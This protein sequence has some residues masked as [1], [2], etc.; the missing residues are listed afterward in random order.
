MTEMTARRAASQPFYQRSRCNLCQSADIE[1]V[2]GL[3]P[4]P[5][6]SPNV[7]ESS[8]ARSAATVRVPLDVYLCHACGH[9]QLVH[10][11][12]PALQYTH[13]QY[14]TAI[15]LGLR[16]HFKTLVDYVHRL[17]GP[18]QGKLVAE[19]GSNDGTV[20]ELFKE[21]GYGV[22]GVDP[23]LEIARKATERGI[24]TIGAFFDQALAESIVG[25]RGKAAA[26]IANNVIANIDDLTGVMSG[27][28]ALLAPDGVFVFETGYGAEVITSTLLD[29]IYHE[30]ISYFV[31]R[32]LPAFLERH[33]LELVDAEIIAS[34][35]GSLRATVQHRNG[36]RPR[37]ANVDRI[38]AAE[39]AAGLDGKAPF[40]AFA[41]R[42][43]AIRD[44][45]TA[46][47]DRRAAQGPAIGYGA[48][49]GSVTLINYFRL[50]Q[51]L[52]FIADDNPLIG[53]LRGPDYEIPVLPSAEIYARRPASAVVLAWRYIEPIKQRHARFLSE[54]G[55]FAVPLPAFSV[56]RGG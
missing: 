4:V 17:I 7:G 40:A 25:E 1:C 42:V 26:I 52:A 48:S 21:L 2:I 24:P 20:L 32:S 3:E 5:C 10:I 15:S 8:E 44:Q 55:E 39:R 33:G 41:A 29:T 53:A 9:I 12:D 35:G 19:F 37:A 54:G 16:Q 56:H 38:I 22:V 34:K 30:H 6:V 47:L 51:R 31:V 50:A 23:A 49:V 45:L 46:Y 27:V 18:A 11:V 14:R 36:P 13:Y 43:G 28:R